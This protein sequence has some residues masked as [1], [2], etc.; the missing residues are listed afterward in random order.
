MGMR[1]L[2]HGWRRVLDTY[3]VRRPHILLVACPGATAVRIAVEGAVPRVGGRFALTPADADILL[4]AGE[5]SDE[6]CWVVEALWEQMPGPRVRGRAVRP[7]GAVGVLQQLVAELCGPGQLRDAARR[8]DEWSERHKRA[9]RSDEHHGHGGEHGHGEGDED[10]GMEMPGG[11]AMA[12]TA[13]DRDGLKLDVLHVPLGPVL[14][15]WPAGLV[16]HAVLQGDVVQEAH[17][18]VVASPDADGPVFWSAAGDHAARRQRVAASYLDSL[19]RLLAVAGWEAAARRA[20]AFRDRAMAELPDPALHED[21]LRWRRRVEKSALLHWSTDRVGVLS[22]E[23]AARLGVGG[24]AARARAPGD[25]TARW[26]QWL[27]ETDALLS[28]G[29][30]PEDGPRGRPGPAGGPSQ[31]LLTAALELMPGLDLAEARLLAASFDPD[32]DEWV[33][34]AWQPS[35]RGE[36]AG[37]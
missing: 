31:A 28:G 33:R 24:P 6:M 25:A 5:P 34:A 32:P 13:P 16:V 12:G 7:D 27:T 2:A 30:L 20:R 10:S 9:E 3:A 36:A 14:P 26:R 35:G 4:V 18:R 8:D 1:T 21:F 29:S 37:R 15:E 22:A 17:G 11:L 23:H 19:G